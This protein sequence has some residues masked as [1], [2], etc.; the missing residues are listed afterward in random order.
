[1]AKA[2][3]KRRD[4]KARGR[5]KRGSRGAR[6]TRR[7]RSKR[8]EGGK[9]TAASP[10]LRCGS[11]GLW[12]PLRSST[13]GARDPGGMGGGARRNEPRLSRRGEGGRARASEGERAKS[14]GLCET[15][16]AKERGERA[17]GEKI[18]EEKNQRKNLAFFS[19]API[20]RPEREHRS[21]EERLVFS[22]FLHFF[23]SPGR[24]SHAKSKSRGRLWLG[25]WSLFHSLA[26]VTSSRAL[27][28]RAAEP[29]SSPRGCQLVGFERTE[30]IEAEQKRRREEE[31]SN[32]CRPP[33]GPVPRQRTLPLRVQVCDVDERALAIAIPVHGR[34]R[35]LPA[36]VHVVALSSTMV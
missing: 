11:R 7:L 12:L 29:S 20:L 2:A 10:G 16:C 6:E 34:V 33:S 3:G 18:E 24:G 1:M 36:R 32:Q 21:F 22:P 19:L 26:R 17:E 23:S 5:R 15:G 28:R 14:L 4:G 27:P 9:R 8:R 13:S 25:G 31:S 35:G 30:R